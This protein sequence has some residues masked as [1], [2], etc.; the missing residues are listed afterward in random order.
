MIVPPPRAR[1]HGRRDDPAGPLNYAGPNP[2]VHCQTPQP[3]KLPT[4][5]DLF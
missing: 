3:S 2:K 4:P 1:R 5:R